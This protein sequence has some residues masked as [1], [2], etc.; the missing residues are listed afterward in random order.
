[1]KNPMPTYVPLVQ[2]FSARTVLFQGAIARDLGLNTTEL[3]CYR[4]ISLAESGITATELA[5]SNAVTLPAIT[6]IVDRLEDRGFIRRE[7]DPHDRRRVLLY[8]AA[9]GIARTDAAYERYSKRI[10]PYLA[11]YSTTEFE[12]IVRFLKDVE[13]IM[14]DHLLAGVNEPAAKRAPSRKTGK[15]TRRHA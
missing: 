12:T 2:R 1:M 7:R 3:I 14:R 15:S 13:V 4:L 5:Q 11:G 10:A 9:K 6:A 8:P